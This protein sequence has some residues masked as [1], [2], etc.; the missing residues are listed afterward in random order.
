MCIHIKPATSEDIPYLWDM[1]YEAIHMGDGEERPPR[2][3]LQKPELAN[4]VENWGRNGDHALI[5]TDSD[6]KKIGAV[7]IRFFKD[8]AKVYGFV[9]EQ[10]PIL[11]MA[12]SHDYRGKGIGTKLMNEMCKLASNHSY[13]AISLSV[14]PSNPALRLYER[15]GFK[16]I[17]VDGTSWNMMISL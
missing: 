14:D 15:F 4:Y 17:G 2:S 10:T 7:W 11:S 8:M 3:I 9:D 5:A 12:I 6:G 13:K 16:K 1:L